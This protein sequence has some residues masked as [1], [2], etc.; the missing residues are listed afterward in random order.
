MTVDSNQTYLYF[1]RLK[2]WSK[3]K[4]VL[5]FINHLEI[6]DP[7]R[8]VFQQESPEFLEYSLKAEC[9]LKYTLRISGSPDMTV[10]NIH[11]SRV[12]FL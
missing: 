3:M 1:P 10:I 8:I 11:S 5:L 2:R 9:G 6:G 12:S 4:S 7:G